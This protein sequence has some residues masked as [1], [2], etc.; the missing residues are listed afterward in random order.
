MVDF[1]KMATPP[2]RRRGLP[3]WDNRTA[4]DIKALAL[5][6]AE[7]DKVLAAMVIAT[8]LCGMTPNNSVMFLLVKEIASI[9]DQLEAE[10]GHR[11]GSRPH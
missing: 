8:I 6:M 2:P 11:Y 1:N 7:G 10:G 5:G 4:D 3:P 9:A